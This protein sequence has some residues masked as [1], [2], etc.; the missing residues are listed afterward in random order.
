MVRILVVSTLGAPIG[1]V[2]SGHTLI[3]ICGTKRP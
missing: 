1:L 3:E 2:T